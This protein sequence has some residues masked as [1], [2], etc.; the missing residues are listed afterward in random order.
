MAIISKPQIVYKGVPASFTLFKTNLISH[1]IV[2]ANPR[3]SDFSNWSKVNI[4]YKSSQGNQVIIV[5]FNANDN[6]QFG[7]FIASERARTYFNVDSIVIVDLD[8]EILKVNRSDLNTATFDLTLTG[9]SE[10]EEF[11]LLMEDG[12]SFLLESGDFLVLE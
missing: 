1:H 6:F 9:N 2:S 4:N 7:Q 5:E 12:T 11:V 8:G 10:S 3:F